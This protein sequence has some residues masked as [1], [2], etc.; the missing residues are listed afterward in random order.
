MW[1]TASPLKSQPMFRR[2]MS[3]PSSGSK[4][5]LSKKVVWNQVASRVRLTLNWLLGVI[6]QNTE[7]FLYT[8]LLLQRNVLKNMGPVNTSS[9]GNLSEEIHLNPWEIKQENRPN[10][11][12]RHPRC[13]GRRVLCEGQHARGICSRILM[14]C[15]QS[16][17]RPAHGGR[18]H[19]HLTHVIL[20]LNTWLHKNKE[21]CTSITRP[22][23][24]H[25]C[26]LTPPDAAAIPAV[27]LSRGIQHSS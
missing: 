7:L 1:Q 12:E 6:S 15:A 16:Q 21:P 11:K 9:V 4:N 22:V 18:S 24:V 3:P 26:N 23:R 17:Y 14:F 27:T 5:K 25:I 20:I 8:I 2:S 10:R 19:R 13:A